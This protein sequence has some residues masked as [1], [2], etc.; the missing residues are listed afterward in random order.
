MQATGNDIRYTMD[1]VTDPTMN[2]GMVLQ[3][4]LAP[5]WFEREDLD[6]I[7]LVPGGAGTATLEVHYYRSGNF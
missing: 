7:R 2:I 6:N 3:N 1:G 5:E 4:G